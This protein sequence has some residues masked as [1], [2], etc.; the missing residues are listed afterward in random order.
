MEPP[1]PDTGG[2]WGSF[3]APGR[4]GVFR[5]SPGG[6][7]LPPP[8]HPGSDCCPG[9]GEEMKEPPGLHK[10]PH[11]PAR[12]QVG[13]Q[14]PRCPPL[15]QPSSAQGHCGEAPFSSRWH[16]GAMG[17]VKLLPKNFNLQSQAEPSAARAIPE[18]SCCLAEPAAKAV[19]HAATFPKLL[20]FLRLYPLCSDFFHELI[21]ESNFYVRG[22]KSVASLIWS[23]VEAELG[24]VPS[25]GWAGVS[26]GR[27]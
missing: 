3:P 13:T 5:G 25:L 19:L 14:L 22:R 27:I 6:H 16:R 8:S 2:G 24:D 17:W 9:K 23:E 15:P 10:F 18:T 1:S 21:I 4:V 26:Q 7:P 20:L 12:H 11:T